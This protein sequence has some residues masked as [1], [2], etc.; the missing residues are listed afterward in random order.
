MKNPAGSRIQVYSRGLGS[1]P[2]PQQSGCAILA[3]SDAKQ[4]F[5]VCFPSH[6][7]LSD[8]FLKFVV[9][10]SELCLCCMVSMI[11]SYTT[12]LCFQLIL[13]MFLICVGDLKTEKASYSSN[14]VSPAILHRKELRQINL[15]VLG[16]LGRVEWE[17]IERHSTGFFGTGKDTQFKIYSWPNVC[18]IL[19]NDM[20]S[21]V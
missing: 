16:K 7:G 6:S 17:H 18:R 2:P 15:Q 12:I 4:D 5:E 20:F 21:K 3:W 14:A 19:Q 13:V 9:F 11:Y 1:Q 10:V 8:V